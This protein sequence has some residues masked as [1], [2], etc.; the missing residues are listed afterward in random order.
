M[1]TIPQ[2][3]KS[4]C[5]KKNIDNDIYVPDMPSDIPEDQKY[6]WTKEFQKKLKE[7]EK[8]VA[9]GKTLGPLDNFKDACKALDI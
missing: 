6:F 4:K 9:E 5:S 7:A 3:K 1:K 2:K 8:E